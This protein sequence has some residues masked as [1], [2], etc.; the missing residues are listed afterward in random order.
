M[1]GRRL[2]IAGG[3]HV[4]TPCLR[5][6]WPPHW[7]E[8]G[9]Q[10]IA[11]NRE[12]AQDAFVKLISHFRI[13]AAIFILTVSPCFAWGPAHVPMTRSAFD[14]QP[15]EFRARFSKP[16]V[17]Q[18]DGQEKT[19]EWLL[20]HRFSM[21]PD[22][23]DGPCRNPED[24]PERLRVTRFVYAQRD[25]K[26]MAPIAY[27]DPDKESKGPRPKTYHYFMLKT[28]ELNREF[29]EVGA[30][31]YFKRIALAFKEGRDLDAAEYLGAFAH[32]IEDRVSPYHVWDGYAEQREALEDEFPELQEAGGSWKG[33]PA[34]T[35]LIWA[36]D[37]K[38]VEVDLALYEPRLLGED[39][40]EAAKEFTKRLFQSREHARKIYSEKNGYIAAHLKDDWKAR[41]AGSATVGFMSELAEENAKLVADVMRTAWEFSTK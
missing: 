17:D 5:D 25:G 9:Q 4:C 10:T 8:A 37:G 11:P 33:N 34:S 12:A 18:R 20:S 30:R 31:W 39:I 21:H 14:V 3:A 29:A 24:I 6:A 27:S 23:V 32:A 16:A 41:E 19:I 35:S 40:D 22:A 2:Q 15:P 13:V 28:E 36:L 7:H 38:G 26:F 1:W